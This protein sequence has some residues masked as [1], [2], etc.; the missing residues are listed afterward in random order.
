[1]T[2][3]NRSKLGY[4]IYLTDEEADALKQALEASSMPGVDEILQA[5][6]DADVLVD[7]WMFVK[8]EGEHRVSV[9]WG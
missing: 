6:E 8:A 9:E 5:L 4:R 2:K 1:M 7:E 3:V